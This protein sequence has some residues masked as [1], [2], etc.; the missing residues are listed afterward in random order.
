MSPVRRTLALLVALLS[1][2]LVVAPSQAATT[3]HTARAAKP[4]CSR[5]LASYPI[6]RPGDRKAAVRTLQC[7]L[8][9]VGVGPVVVDGFY[10]PQTKAAVKKIT[11]GFEGAVPHPYRINNG[12][13][14]LL[15]GVQLPDSNLALGAH[16]S[17]VTVL[18]RALRAAG[19][20]IVVDGSFG[21][22]TEK[23]V[24]AYQK[25][26]GVHPANGV[27]NENTRF[28]LGMGGVFGEL[29]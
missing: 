29:S 3:H 14:T 4:V 10:G 22:Q 1:S 11:D 7:S 23:V 18:Q 5:T 13:W 28:F 17:A 19:A 16:G 6:L 12:M 25:E 27:V 2:L 24:K 21:T 8:N 15:F 20:T 9:D 26:M